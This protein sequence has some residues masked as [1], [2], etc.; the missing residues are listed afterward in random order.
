MSKVW[1]ISDSSNGVG[2][3]LAEAVLASGDRLVAGAR[4]PSLLT[5]LLDVH[6]GRMCAVALDVTDEASI[7][8]AI[9]V[10]LSRFGRIDVLVSSTGYVAFDRVEDVADAN[11]RRQ[12]ESN[13]FGV[14]NLTQAV[15]PILRQQG[16]GHII[17]WSACAGARG[18]RGLAA[19]QAT[20]LALQGFHEVL[21]TEIEPLGLHVT[22]VESGALDADVN[23][24]R[25]RAHGHAELKPDAV[26]DANPAPALALAVETIERAPDAPLG[27]VTAFALDRVLFLQASHDLLRDAQASAACATSGRAQDRLLHFP[28]RPAAA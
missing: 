15:L 21:A 23:I 4:D 27:R 9:N 10:A 13:F 20:T 14:V 25:L 3:A 7:Y 1:L 24:R 16:S 11:L 18:V 2:R 8:A 5:G 12:F 6:D 26:E 19:H 17:H 28:R 22:L